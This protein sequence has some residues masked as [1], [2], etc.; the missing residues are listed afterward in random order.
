[1]MTSFSFR[2]GLRPRILLATLV[3]MLV[4]LG[5]MIYAVSSFLEVL[6]HD[7]THGQLARELDRVDALYRRDPQLL[8]LLGPNLETYV[9]PKGDTDSLPDLPDGL[10]APMN[11]I[12]MAAC[13]SSL[14]VLSRS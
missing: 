5:G 7:M 10:L 13:G 6:E 3:P 8:D 11:S 12:I 2:P 4:V 14:M 9:V 1:M